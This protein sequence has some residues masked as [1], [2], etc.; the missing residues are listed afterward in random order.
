MQPDAPMGP[1]AVNAYRMIGAMNAD[2]RKTQP[3]PVFAERIAGSGF[4]LVHDLL[5]LCFL[6]PLNR[7]RHAPDRIFAHLDHRE[8]ADRGSQ[9]PAWLPDRDRI[10]TAQPAVLEMK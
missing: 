2:H 7:G 1:I 3:D 4:D 10:R 6:F 9:L 8:R 5:A